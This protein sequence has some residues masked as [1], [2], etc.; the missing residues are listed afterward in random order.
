MIAMFTGTTI[1][2]LIEAVQKA[3]RQ[4]RPVTACDMPVKVSRYEVKQ[5]FVYAMQFAETAAV[6]GAA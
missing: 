4:A 6:V 2:E 5:G 1:D 3:E